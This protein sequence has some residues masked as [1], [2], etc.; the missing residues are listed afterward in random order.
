MPLLPCV[1]RYGERSRVML[2][3]PVTGRFII[4]SALMSVV[5]AQKVRLARTQGPYYGGS[6]PN[7][8]Q[9]GRNASELQGSFHS[10]LDSS[11]S[12]RH[13]GL[14]ERV[15]R[16]RRFVSPSRPYRRQMDNSHS[17]AVY[18]SPPLDPSWRRNWNSNFPWD[19]SQI[20]HQL[21]T[22]ALNRTNSDSALHTSVMNP[23]AGDPFAGLSLAAQGRQAVISYPVPPIEENGPDDG[24]LLKPWDSRKLPLLSSRP[25]SCEV[26]GI[27]VFPSPDQ[28]GGASHGASVLNTGGSLPDLSSLHFPSPLPTPLDPEEPG[29]PSLSGGSST[30]NL[31]CTLTQLGINSSSAFHSTGLLPSLQGTLSNPSLQSSLSNPNIRSSLSSHSFTNSLSSASLHSSL[32]NPSLQSSLSSS[33]SLRSSLSSQSLQSSLSNSSLQSAASNPSYGGSGSFA[34]HT[35]GQGVALDTSKLQM[36]QRL[37]QYSFGQQQVQKGPVPAQTGVH[38]HR[39]SSQTAQLHQH[40]MQ[41]LHKTQNFQMQ[42]PNQNQNPGSY[43]SVDASQPDSQTEQQTGQNRPLPALQQI[44]ELDLYNDSMFLNSLLDE[45]YLNLQLS[46]RQKQN[47]SLSQQIGLDS[48]DLGSGSVKAHGQQG[49]LELLESSEQQMLSHNQCQTYSDGRH[50]VPNII[51]TGDSPSGLSKE[52][53]HALSGVPGFE[54]DPFSSDDSLRMDPLALEG[55]GMLTDGDLMLADPAVEDSFRS[56]HLK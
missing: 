55:L 45:P 7:V 35:P 6:L 34:P 36:D 44:S 46:S 50:T 47:L 28:Q 52:I 13:H 42:R 51:L 8:N 20:F 30:G 12:T 5:Q 43:G 40:N 11:R 49:A 31:T 33:P 54:M 18:L 10:P 1:G 56:D 39:P 37:S 27:T 14:V 48:H 38:T 41:N 2:R 29:Y 53:T 26:P 22:A 17:S 9:I 25:K 23:P 24:R 21:P 15:H 19:K 4:S 32:S 3:S 16:D